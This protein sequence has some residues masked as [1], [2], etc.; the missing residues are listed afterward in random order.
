MGLALPVLLTPP[1]LKASALLSSKSP[2]RVLLSTLNGEF[3][4]MWVSNTREPTRMS[5]KRESPWTAPDTPKA[6]PPSLT[7]PTLTL[8][9]TAQ[10]WK[11]RRI[12]V[13][14]TEVGRAPM[15]PNRALDWLSTL[16]PSGAK[17]SDSRVASSHGVP[18]MAWA[19]DGVVPPP[20]PVGGGGGGITP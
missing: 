1:M 6:W 14:H 3:M 20:L 12:S 8:A 10:V 2:A 5:P 13:C 15:V 18:K 17:L 19:S 11:A 7:K 9:L 4:A 16:V